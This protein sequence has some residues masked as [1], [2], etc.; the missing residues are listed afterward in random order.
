MTLGKHW[1]CKDSPYKYY[2]NFPFL[3]KSETTL[4]V[5]HNSSLGPKVSGKCL[6]A[7]PESWFNYADNSQTLRLVCPSRL[8]YWCYFRWVLGYEDYYLI[9]KEKDLGKHIWLF[10]PV[11]NAWVKLTPEAMGHKLPCWLPCKSERFDPESS[12]ETRVKN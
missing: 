1:I 3:K 9:C 7:M 8:K 10:F 2:C 4:S 11:S 6:Y 5:W 12:Q